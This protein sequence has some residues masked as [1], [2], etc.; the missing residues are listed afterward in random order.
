MPHL[1]Y[2]VQITDGMTKFCRHDNFFKTRDQ[3]RS[4]PL[5]TVQIEAARNEHEPFQVVIAALQEDLRDVEIRIGE[6]KTDAGE[7]ADLQVTGYRAHAIRQPIHNVFYPDALFPLRPFD[8][9]KG[10]LQSIWFDLRTERDTPPGLYESTVMVHPAGLEPQSVTVRLLVH[11]FVL[12]DRA[13]TKTAFGFTADRLCRFHNVQPGTPAFQEVHARY[14]HFLIEHGISPY[15]LPVPQ[16]S[17]QMRVYLDDPRV[18]TTRMPYSDDLDILRATIQRYRDHGW[19]DKAFLYPVDEPYTRKEYER[20]QR[21]ADQIHAIE[22]AAKVVC[23]YFRSP[24]FAPTTTALDHLVEY[25]D[26]WC[27]LNAHFEPERLKIRQQAGD[28][29]WWYV[30]CIPLRPYPNLSIDSEP[31]DVRALFWLQKLYNVEG[32]LYWSVND[33]TEDPYTELPYS[34]LDS[35]RMRAYSGGILL[36]PGPP[37]GVDGPVSSIRLELIREG[38]EDLHYFNLLQEQGGQEELE[39]K[40]REA[41]VGLTFYERDPRTFKAVRSRIARRLDQLVGVCVP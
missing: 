2:T 18:S 21:A 4:S 31:V 1:P 38:L 30:C 25:V 20:L 41:V 27:P 37:I 5:D 13:S 34:W 16:D 28:H 12:P 8:L 10:E 33:W 22:P 11:A 9:P 35:R 29:V 24:E 14:V 23:P 17:E 7:T 19:L 32:L 39:R 3:F 15:D 6:F 36:Y 40:L 26:I